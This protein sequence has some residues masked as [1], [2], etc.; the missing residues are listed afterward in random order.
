MP[1]LSVTAQVSGFGRPLAEEQGVELVDLTF[2]KEGGRW[3]LRVLLDKPAGVSVDDCEKYSQALERML[4]ASQIINGAY[5]LE[6]SSAGLDRPLKKDADFERFKGRVIQVHTYA[7][8]DERRNFKGVLLGLEK[9]HVVLEDQGQKFKVPQ[10]MI[11][12]ANL[13]YEDGLEKEKE[14]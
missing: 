14:Q 7:P 3:I 9:G 5:F 12:K 1:D 13:D 6:V 2:K 4:D 11:A 8:V 10:D